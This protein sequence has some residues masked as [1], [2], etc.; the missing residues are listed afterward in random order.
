MKKVIAFLLTLVLIFS[1]IGC[2]IGE[3]K[4]NIFRLVEKNYDTILIACEEQDEA[5]LLA[6]NG[7]SSVNITDGYVIAFCKGEGVSVS[8]QDYGFY[9]SFDNSPVAIGCN[10]GIVCSADELEPKEKGFQCT[11]NGN[12]FYT[13][14]IKGNL[15]FYSNSY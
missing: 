6:I 10:L 13:E 1:L 7:V 15:Y 3:P 11:I 9:Y 2:D 5:A 8:S 4:S 12:T 14:H